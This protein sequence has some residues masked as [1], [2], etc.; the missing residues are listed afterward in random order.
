MLSTCL[1]SEVK[2][3]NF[4]HVLDSFHDD[5]LV[6]YFGTSKCGPC[7]LMKKE[8]ITAKKILGKDNQHHHNIKIFSLDTE[9]WPHLGTRYGIQRLPCIIVVRDGIVRKR[10]DGVTKAD[11]LVKELYDLT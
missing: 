11:L 2:F 10:F 7:H 3:K 4:D 8:L 5:T 6:L 9:K 1:Y